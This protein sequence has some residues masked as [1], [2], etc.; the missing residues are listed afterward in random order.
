M[1]RTF[2]ACQPVRI[3]PS[4]PPSTQHPWPEPQPSP[5]LPSRFRTNS[6]AVL[7]RQRH[8]R[9][10]VTPV[11]DF[12]AGVFVLQP[13]EERPQQLHVG[14]GVIHQGL[15]HLRHGAAGLQ[16]T[17]RGGHSGCGSSCLIQAAA[18]QTRR[19]GKALGSGFSPTS[20]SPV[21][22]ASHGRSSF[23]VPIPGNP[24]QPF[25]LPGRRADGEDE[26]P[27]GANTCV[28]E[29]SGWGQQSCFPS[30]LQ[31]RSGSVLK[32]QQGSVN[33]LPRRGGGFAAV[34]SGQG[35]HVHPNMLT[36]LKAHS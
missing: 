29:R 18:P 8:N 16:N 13:F 1:Q 24:L 10:A 33:V 12:G 6:R 19:Q 28:G 22:P 17:T 31:E 11:R 7:Y 15:P 34:S 14:V 5:A 2:S 26:H 35:T 9:L 32:V 23:L 36:T 20:H 30:P 27:R 3:K 25:S 4:Q 21:A